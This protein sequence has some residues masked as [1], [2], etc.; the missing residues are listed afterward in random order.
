VAFLRD[1]SDFIGEDGEIDLPDDF[2]ALNGT[3]D[4]NEYGAEVELELGRRRALGFVLSAGYDVEDYNNTTSASLFDE[5]SARV[6]IETILRFSPVSTGTI[7]LG[8]EEVD[9]ADTTDTQREITT[10]DFG[11]AHEVSARTRLTATLG[12]SQTDRQ[13]TAGSSR[14]D[15][16]TGAV[17]V[18]YALPNGEIGGSLG[19]TRTEGDSGVIGSLNWRQDLPTG[20]ISAELTHEIDIATDGGT[21]PETALDVTYSHEVNAVSGVEFGLTHVIAGSTPTSN[22][23]SQ[24]DL[25]VS[26]RRELTA[27]WGLNAGLRYQV[28]REATVGT[29]EAP[30]AFL[31]IGRQFDLR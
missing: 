5:T 23:I 10:L 12:F 15:T 7:A 30:F 16:V 6:G 8:Y 2:G 19:L 31:T 27:D 25:E 26:Y 17:G 14:D 4:L 22:R 20:S 21:R 28:R 29:A 11:Y 3:G 9:T 1:L 24:T 18:S 13:T